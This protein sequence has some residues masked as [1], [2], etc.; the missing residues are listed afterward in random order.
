[1][2]LR[3]NSNFRI[4]VLTYFSVIDNSRI[5]QNA[6]FME[7]FFKLSFWCWHFDIEQTSINFSSLKDLILNQGSTSR[8]NSRT[9]KNWS[10]QNQECL[11]YFIAIFLL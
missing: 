5:N 11:S 7:I 1:M 4:F 10:G 8:P 3:L 9:K 2:V 6:S